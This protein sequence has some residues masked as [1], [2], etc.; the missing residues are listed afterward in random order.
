MYSKYRIAPDQFFQ[1]VGA[2]SVAQAPGTQP[3]QA[4]A[5]AGGGAADGTQTAAQSTFADESNTSRFIP[6]YTMFDTSATG[7]PANEDFVI[8]RPFVPFS[9]NDARTELQAYMTASS[10]PETYGKL[11]SYIV[12]ETNNRLP[13]GPLR[14]ASQAESTEAISRRISLDNVGGGGTEVRFGDLQLIQVSQG[15]VWVR[16]YYLSVA[17][18]SSEVTSVTEYRGVIVSYN[19]QAVLED[20]VSEALTALF[21]GFNG[22][23]GETIAQPTEPDAGG[24]GGE[25]PSNPTTE[26]DP[27]A[28]GDDPVA[29]LELADQAFIEAD[30]ALADSDLGLYQQKIAEARQLIAD[31][32]ALLEQP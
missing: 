14:V 7:E 9:T 13:D 5:P 30:A 28:S 10:A 4:A 31:A 16:P 2:W 12:E 1:R 32:F 19:D 24:G 26:P 18:N 15:L 20:T 25:D 8:L 11:T 22:E 27:G 21:P 17:Q 3:S 29:L 6:Y 23:V